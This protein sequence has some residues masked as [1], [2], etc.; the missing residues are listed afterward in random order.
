VRVPTIVLSVLATTLVF[1]TSASATF[2]HVV[3]P[4]ESLS[5]I[6]TTDGLTVAQLAAANGVPPTTELTAGSQLAIPPQGGGAP[7]EASTPEASSSTPEASEG[8]GDQDS[9]EGGSGVAVSERTSSRYTVAPGDTLSALAARAGTTVAQLAAANGLDPSGP[10]LSGTTLTL[11]GA[12][13]GPQAASTASASTS[14]PTGTAAA[15]SPGGPPYPTPQTVGSAEIASIAAANGVPPSLAEAIAYQESGFNNELVSSA[16]ARG[17]MQIT[18]GTWS[19]IGEKLAGP[20]P[21]APASVR[22][23]VR[24]GVLLLRAL[25]QATGSNQELAAAGYYQGLSS[26]RQEGMYPSTQQYV[27]DVRALQSRFG[28]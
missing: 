16:N 17:V 20:M 28:G 24:G 6:A 13:G 11:G 9:D 12:V 2:I 18:P 19:W 1:A 15:G 27:A 14:Q 3:G 23:N 21:L 10:L 4:G 22:D 8:D 5:S 26:V 25:L 7:L